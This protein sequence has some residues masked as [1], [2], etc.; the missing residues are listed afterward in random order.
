MVMSPSNSQILQRRNLGKW[1]VKEEET[2]KAKELIAIANQLGSGE[3]I[4]SDHPFGWLRG[5]DSEELAELIAETKEAISEANVDELD[6]VIY[7]WHESAIAI[8][9]PELTEAFFTNEFEEEVVL[10]KP[11]NNGSAG[12]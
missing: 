3:K 7:E 11:E 5:F 1:P 6:A 8:E 4:S 9:S 12:F 2:R 10:T